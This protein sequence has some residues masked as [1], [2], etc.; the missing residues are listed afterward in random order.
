MDFSWM[1]TSSRKSF[2]E[3]KHHLS[4]TWHLHISSYSIFRP[5][6]MNVSVYKING[7]EKINDYN[8]HVLLHY[9]SG[10]KESFWSYY[11]YWH[12]VYRKNIR[13]EHCLRIL[14]ALEKNQ[15]LFRKRTNYLYRLIESTEMVSLSLKRH[16]YKFENKCLLG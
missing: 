3:I 15:Q 14:E 2:I 5:A 8:D 10:A 7:L 12:F 13:M 16:L 4:Y 11:S 1:N 6:F 9:S